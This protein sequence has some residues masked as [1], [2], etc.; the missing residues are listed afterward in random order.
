MNFSEYVKLSKRTMRL[1]MPKRDQ[2]INI[3]LGIAGE[4]GEVADILKKH[5]FH[6]YDLDT[7]LRII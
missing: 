5:W 6:G 4:L 3:K 2:I 1:D 7:Q